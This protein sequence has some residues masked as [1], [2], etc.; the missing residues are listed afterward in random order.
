[1]FLGLNEM[2]ALIEIYICLDQPVSILIALSRLCYARETCLGMR[3]EHAQT[4]TTS[5]LSSLY[6]MGNLFFHEMNNIFLNIFFHHNLQ[7]FFVIPQAT[8]QWNIDSGVSFILHQRLLLFPLAVFRSPHVQE[9]QV[10]PNI[11]ISKQYRYIIY[12]M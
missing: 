2:I 3:T 6:S 11:Y 4:T 8:F 7:R 9:G 12:L 5:L 10:G 1:M